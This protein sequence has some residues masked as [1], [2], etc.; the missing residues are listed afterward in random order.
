[1]IF[2]L[3]GK[4]SDKIKMINKESLETL[5]IKNKKFKSLKV[6]LLDH[7]ILPLVFAGVLSVPYTL[8]YVIQ[9]SNS[10]TSYSSSKK[11]SYRFESTTMPN[12]FFTTKTFKRDKTNNSITDKVCINNLMGSR[13]YTDGENGPYDGIVDDILEDPAK[14]GND[15]EGATKEFTKIKS[16]FRKKLKKHGIE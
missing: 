6:R 1:M 7:L 14:Y 5:S 8:F 2:T 4:S 9:A 3:K 12:L 15:Y 10:R 11:D 16:Q 13:S